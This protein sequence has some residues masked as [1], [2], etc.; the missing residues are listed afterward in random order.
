MTFNEAEAQAKA[1]AEQYKTIM[2]VVELKEKRHYSVVSEMR[3]NS[4]GIEE[5][6]VA[7]F[8]PTP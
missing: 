8:E 4:R 6:V 1:N 7:V 5:P 2:Y 3:Y